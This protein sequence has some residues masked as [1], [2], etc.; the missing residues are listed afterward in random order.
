MRVIL[1]Y[2][3]PGNSDFPVAR[4]L[5]SVHRASD[6]DECPAPMH[7]FN[8][9]IS[10]ALTAGLLLAAIGVLFVV[11]GG[12]LSFVDWDRGGAPD[13]AERTIRVP[14]AAREL[15]AR[16]ATPS[17][18]PARAD[19]ARAARTPAASRPG[20][21]AAVAPSP[22]TRAD[23][24]RAPRPEAAPPRRRPAPEPP[25]TP[26]ENPPPAA[27]PPPVAQPAAPPPPPPGPP[28]AGRRPGPVQELAAG[29]VGTLHAATTEL[30]RGLGGAPP[31]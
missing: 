26:P 3:V 16:R 21:P 4:V 12:R 1:E 19:R 2:T 10:T 22:R 7:R 11:A 31:P 25:A 9:Y 30:T 5:K 17:P 18:A 14:G 15:P 23:K 8:A 24:P 13:Q 28:P 6:P 29:L 20:A 27:D